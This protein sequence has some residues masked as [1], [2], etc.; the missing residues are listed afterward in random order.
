MYIN[1]KNINRKYKNEE[2]ENY[3]IK[4]VI[5]NIYILHFYFLGKSSEPENNIISF[6][7]KSINK[8]YFRLLSFLFYQLLK[9]IIIQRIYISTMKN[10]L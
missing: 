6:S 3:L 4:C 7:S 10:D 8:L 5:I 1:N 9:Y 2:I